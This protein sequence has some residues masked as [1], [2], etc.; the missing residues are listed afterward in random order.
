MICWWE[1]RSGYLF[2]HILPHFILEFADRRCPR[3]CHNGAFAGERVQD[4]LGGPTEEAG[5]AL[6]L[7][8]SVWGA[9]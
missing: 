2:L 3:A 6:E 1:E 5:C 8:N 7:I 9:I 4:L